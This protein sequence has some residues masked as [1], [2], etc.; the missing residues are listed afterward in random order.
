MCRSDGRPLLLIMQYCQKGDLTHFLS[1]DEHE[2]GK[3]TIKIKERLR[4]CKEVCEGMSYLSAK[5]YVHRDLAA[6]NVLVDSDFVCKVSDFGLSRDIGTEGGGDHAAMYYRTGGTAAVPVR[7]TALEA[8]EEHVFTTASDVWSFGILA[9]EVFSD[10][11]TPYYGMKN[12]D[13]WLN[14]RAGMRHD[15]PDG[16]PREIFKRVMRDC[17][18]ENPK[19]RPVQHQP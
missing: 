3:P 17:W 19:K 13:V 11:E 4:I 6:R 5:N 18:E 8:L 15:R 9:V 2:N 7:W 10:C 1:P 16:C 12:H 14:L